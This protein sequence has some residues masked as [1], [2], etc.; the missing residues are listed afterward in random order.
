MPIYVDDL[1]NFFLLE[2][3]DDNTIDTIDYT[4]STYDE[5]FESVD[6]L[7]AFDA[8]LY[9]GNGCPTPTGVSDD[10]SDDTDSEIADDDYDLRDSHSELDRVITV[11]PD[12]IDQSWHNSLA[13]PPT[14]D[15]LHTMHLVLESFLSWFY[16]SSTPTTHGS[17]VR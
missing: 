16:D 10:D 14:A 1:R 5:H 8:R 17:R 13:R 9:F 3:N 12:F 6:I 15:E 11:N 2:L 7:D 4:E